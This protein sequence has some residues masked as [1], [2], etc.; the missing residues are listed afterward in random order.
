MTKRPHIGH[1]GTSG[2]EMAHNEVSQCL[3]GGQGQVSGPL[4]LLLGHGDEVQRP[5]WVCR[6]YKI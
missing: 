2:Q 4:V 1:V 5:N 3:Q 6:D